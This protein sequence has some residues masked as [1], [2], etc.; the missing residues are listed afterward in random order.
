M[1]RIIIR[2]RFATSNTACGIGLFARELSESFCPPK[3]EQHRL[4]STIPV[5]SIPSSNSNAEHFSQAIKLLILVR[6]SQTTPPS[7][8]LG[9]STDGMSPNGQGGLSFGP[10]TTK[11]VLPG[12]YLNRQSILSIW[13]W[14]T[15]RVS[16]LCK[17]SVDYLS[18]RPCPWSE[19][20][21]ERDRVSTPRLQGVAPIPER[22]QTACLHSPP[23][24][25]RHLS[26]MLH[27]YNTVYA[28]PCLVEFVLRRSFRVSRSL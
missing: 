14:E 17:G 5:C 9:P 19:L 18:A 6:S 4:S 24:G 15:C 16:P 11:P 13:D 2:Y 25:F 26:R 20:A 3:G 27:S 7:L 23:S 12:I 8:E 1:S 21:A 28:I 22:Q 10:G